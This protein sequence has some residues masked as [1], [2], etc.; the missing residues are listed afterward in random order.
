MSINETFD[1][2]FAPSS[3]VGGAIAVIRVSGQ[4]TREIAE[5]ILDRDV[6]K[7]PGR[8]VHTRILRGG[9]VAD[10]GMAVFFC[11]PHSY[12]GEDMLELHCHGGYATVRTVLALLSEAGGAPAPAGEFTKR[13][14][15]NGKMD[16]SSLCYF[17]P[18]VS[19]D[20]LCI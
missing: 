14:F 2:V 7:D 15:L 3:A 6:C 4:K 9:D 5:T 16:L 20:I 13:A 10:D 1:T 19:H 18:S 8:L 11:A 17:Q 12:T